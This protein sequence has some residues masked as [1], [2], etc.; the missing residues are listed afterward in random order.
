[1]TRLTLAL[2]LLG[3]L[4]SAGCA[5]VLTPT[6]TEGSLS[7]LEGAWT[8]KMTQSGGIMGMVRKIEIQSDGS[9]IVTDER[10][11]I[12][13]NGQL[14]EQELAALTARISSTKYST[15]TQQHACADC[16][17]YD[18]E[19]SRNEEWFVAQV[20]DVSLSESGLE[21]LVSDL[22]KIMER[23]LQ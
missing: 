19:I 13:N 22:R 11:S 2:A 12:T 3:V 18:L 16:F 6:P 4:L 14:T 15:Y 7:A 5:P 8:I 1:M 17:I 9:C 21:P 20:D 23:E 10:A